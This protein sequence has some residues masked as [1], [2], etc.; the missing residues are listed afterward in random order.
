MKA[1]K[2][3]FV[4]FIYLFFPGEA[5]SFLPFLRYSVISA[6]DMLLSLIRF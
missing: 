4:D 3:Q 2:L 1:N 5:H 6:R